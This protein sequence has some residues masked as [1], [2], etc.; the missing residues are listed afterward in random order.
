MKSLV[1][2]GT[3]YMKDIYELLNDVDIDIN[4]FEHVEVSKHEREQV[5]KEMKKRIHMNKSSKWK[6]TMTAASIA[7]GISSASLF[8]LSFTT[9]AE[10]IPIIGGIFKFFNDNG[11]YKEYDANANMLNLVKEDQGIKVTLNEAVFDGRTLYVTYKIESEKDLGEFP[12]VL[13]NLDGEKSNMYAR[14]TEIK[15]TGAHEYAGMLI[16]RFR[17]NGT[18]LTEENFEFKIEGFMVDSFVRNEEI[19]GNWDFQFGLEAIK[20]REQLVRINRV[21]EGITFN[22]TRVTYTPM[23]FIIKYSAST[24]KKI[25][26]KWDFKIFGVEVK[27]NLGNIYEGRPD[28]GYGNDESISQTTTFEKLDPKASTLIIT[29]IVRLL[30]ADGTNE[31][32]EIY[33]DENIKAPDERYKLKPIIVEI[34]K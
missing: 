33:R 13:V 12:S 30:S 15:K 24:D 16:G 32:G 18:N 1:K 4:E 6:K 21:H 34:E 17:L 20:S 10:E 23:S 5:K 28:G 11:L 8:G 14:N 29:P 25:N 19:K 27:D 26:D 9:F 31:H 22:L 7:I 2:V 3:I